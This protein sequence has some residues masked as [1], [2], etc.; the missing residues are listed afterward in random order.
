MVRF[1]RSG[2]AWPGSTCAVADEEATHKPKASEAA[3]IEV[4]KEWQRRM[5]RTGAD[6]MPRALGCRTET[7]AAA[8]PSTKPDRIVSRWGHLQQIFSLW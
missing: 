5:A 8:G 4:G 1:S 6:A 2:S 7:V 3:T